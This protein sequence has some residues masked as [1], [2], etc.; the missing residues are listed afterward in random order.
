MYY[1]EQGTGAPILLIHG[2]GGDAESWGSALE[3]LARLGRVVAYDRRGC[4]RSERP[5]PY[6]RTTPAAHAADAAALLDGLGAVPAV[7]IGRSYGGEVALHLA[8]RSPERVRA[9]ALLEGGGLGL[10]P[11]VDAFLDGTAN[12]IR[13]AV[14]A[15]GPE[16]AG[17]A[18]LRGVLGDAGYE[19]APEGMKA[20]VAANGAA[21]VAEM[22]GLHDQQLDPVRLREIACPALVVGA[23]SSPPPFRRLSETL[24]AALP[25]GRLALVEG[26]HLITPA[27]AQVAS[28]IREVRA[29]AERPAHARQD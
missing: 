15:R 17:E 29:L 19:A 18:L 8:L 26:G 25:N 14:A 22:E 28:F 1:E 24:A 27:D 9:L 2:T 21:I 16:A 13:A 10:S 20:R 11:E 12:R 4:T 3:E 6:R 7:V 5:E 23:E